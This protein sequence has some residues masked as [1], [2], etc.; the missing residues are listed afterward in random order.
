M[1]AASRI[2][3]G[4]DKPYRGGSQQQI[5]CQPGYWSPNFW[6]Q[7]GGTF[8]NLGQSSHLPWLRGAPCWATWTRP[9]V[10]PPVQAITSQS[11]SALKIGCFLYCFWREKARHDPDARLIW[12]TFLRKTRGR[13]CRSWVCFLFCF[14]FCQVL[15][16]KNKAPMFFVC[17]YYILLL[18]LYCILL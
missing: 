13:E 6:Q 9:F 16:N 4:N 2:K 3:V 5:T 11:R 7:L 1:V 10:P 15:S 8:P 14:Q 18:L 17:Q 12:D